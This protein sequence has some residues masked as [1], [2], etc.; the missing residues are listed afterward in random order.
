MAQH[1][2][3][4]GVLSRRGQEYDARTRFH[5]ALT[6]AVGALDACDPVFADGVMPALLAVKLGAVRAY[7]ALR[8]LADDRRR[9]VA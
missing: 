9:A 5:Q 3:S 1:H 2:C 4:G 7:H 8:R 6:S